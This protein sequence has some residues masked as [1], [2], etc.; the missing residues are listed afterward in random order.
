VGVVLLGETVSGLGRL[1]MRPAGVELSPDGAQ[2]GGLVTTAA[3]FSW[4][5]LAAVS[6]AVTGLVV[7]IRRRLEP[8]VPIIADALGYHRPARDALHQSTTVRA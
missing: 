8:V 4:M 2:R 3:A 7:V 5:A 1:G 6:L